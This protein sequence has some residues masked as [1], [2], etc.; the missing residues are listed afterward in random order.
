MS[1]YQR[2]QINVPTAYEANGYTV[3]YVMGL[4][5]AEI[6]KQLAFCSKLQSACEQNGTD[7]ARQNPSIGLQRQQLIAE[8]QRRNG[9]AP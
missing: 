5:D 4:S 2:A 1:E 3:A 7:L 9:V 8:Q 6:A